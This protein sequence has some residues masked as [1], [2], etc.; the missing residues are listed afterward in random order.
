MEATTPLM[1]ELQGPLTIAAAAERREQLLARLPDAEQELV[2]D[3]AGVEAFDS[4]GVQLLLSA[5]RSLQERGA[6]LTL[7]G[8]PDLVRE[9]LA[10]L[11]LE[12]VLCARAG[13]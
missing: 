1:L 13:G 5:R 9:A 11:G 10:A 6:T 12:A 7:R 2:L 3:M 4:A 8:V